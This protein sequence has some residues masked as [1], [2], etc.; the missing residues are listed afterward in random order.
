MIVVSRERSIDGFVLDVTLR[1]AAL[2]VTGS[3]TFKQNTVLFSS[4]HG[5]MRGIKWNL[6][7]RLREDAH[8]SC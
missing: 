8:N 2:S 5:I 3:V 4:S 7:P 1:Q 6:L